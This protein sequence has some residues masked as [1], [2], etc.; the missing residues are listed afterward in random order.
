[1]NEEDEVEWVDNPLLKTENPMNKYKESARKHI[2]KFDGN[3]SWWSVKYKQL[4]NMDHIKGYACYAP[5]REQFDD[6][7]QMLCVGYYCE[8]D[9]E[10]GLAYFDWITNKEKSPW[11]F[12]F[13]DDFELVK[14]DDGTIRGF[15][16]GPETL[17]YAS[18]NKSR[19]CIM[20]NFLIASRSWNE[21]NSH[22]MFWYEAVK[23][24]VDPIYALYHSANFY[25]E[26]DGSIF[27]MN[28]GNMNHWAFAGAF[29]FERAEKSNPHANGDSICYVFSESGKIDYNFGHHAS[30]ITDKL[31][32][33]PVGSIVTK[34]A[35]MKMHEEFR[36]TQKG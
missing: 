21:F 20:M 29:D 2:L 12:L 16:I 9:N 35:F 13:K 19:W 32:P 36:K 31:M 10:A 8:A 14:S 15:F 28:I 23:D 24:G 26:S 5:L 1:M 3:R 18:A 22:I 4:E 11:R 17:K 30:K 34:Q 7:I 25:R 33:V 27:R 6:K